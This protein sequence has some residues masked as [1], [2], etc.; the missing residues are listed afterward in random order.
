MFVLVEMVSKTVTRP[1]TVNSATCCH[2]LSQGGYSGFQMTGMIEGFFGGLKFSILV[3][4]LA[5]NVL[6]GL[7]YMQVG[8]SGYSKQTEDSW[9]CRCIPLQTQTFNP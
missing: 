7:V 8:T 2:T 9:L 1:I 5:S 4:N 6:G 3:N